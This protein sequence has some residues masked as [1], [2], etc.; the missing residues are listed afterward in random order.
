MTTTT[1]LDTKARR[2]EH[3]SA[4][5][6]DAWA[7]REIA[8]AMRAH[9]GKAWTGPKTEA[10]TAKLE[11]LAAEAEEH[12][13]AHPDD[14]CVWQLH[15][16]DGEG[17]PFLRI[18][19]IDGPVSIDAR[20]IFGTVEPAMTMEHPHAYRYESGGRDH[21]LAFG[22]GLESQA[23]LDR[24][25]VAR[26]AHDDA[27][28]E[29]RRHA[30]VAEAVGKAV[31]SELRFADLPGLIREAI[32]RL[33]AA[34]EPEQHVEPSK[35]AQQWRIE[36]DGFYLC[37]DTAGEHY[38]MVAESSEALTFET[39]AL[40]RGYLREHTPLDVR[41]RASIIPWGGG[42]PSDAEQGAES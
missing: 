11:A 12:D 5:D 9:Q 19:T 25:H 7:W 6:L 22:S 39:A 23:A 3:E 4:L 41:E 26:V 2:Q 24:I 34:P 18:E 38:W 29:D 36:K 35:P 17:S 31:A 40:A 33:T 42:A 28:A 21:I 30:L 37:K 1:T 27:H 16:P 13:A 10:L 8:V 20:S 14:P 15:G 32:E